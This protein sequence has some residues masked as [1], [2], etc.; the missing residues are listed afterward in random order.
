MRVS[1]GDAHDTEVEAAAASARTRRAAKA[2]GPKPGD[3]L[4]RFVILDVLGAGGMG[5]VYSAY[6]PQL[7]RR[8]AIKLLRVDADGKNAEMRLL[9][10]AQAMARIDHPNVIKVHDVGTQDGEV[11]LAME[12]SDAGTL[13]KWLAA[14]ARSIPEIV[15]AFVQAGRGL[16]AA[17]AAGLVHRDFKP[18][19]VLVATNGSVRVTDFGLVG[20]AGDPVAVPTAGSSGPLALDL[21]RTGAVLGTPSYM[22]PEQFAGETA[23]EASDQ[24]AFCV[25][26]YEACYGERPFRG[27]SHLD[28]ASRVQHGEIEPAPAGKRVPDWLRR[29]V[30][31]G[32]STDTARRY[33]SM[34]ALLDA[35]GGTSRRRR[36]RIAI[37]IGGAIA[38]CAAVAGTMVLL[39][40]DPVA[41]CAS[42]AGDEIAKVWSPA[43]RTD[44]ERAFA[45]SS[46][47]LA[48]M[49]IGRL[50]SIV[51]SWSD[52][53]QHAYGD[54]CRASRV[55]GTQSEHLFDLRMECLARRRDQAGASIALLAAG[56]DDAV[57]HALDVARGLPAVAPCADATALTAQVAPPENA[58]TASQVQ[59]I[60]LQIDHAHA[61]EKL[62][63]YKEARDVAAGALTAARAT[64]YRPIVA[65][66]LLEIGIA[67]A[68]LADRAALAS[69]RESMHVATEAGD[70]RA[71]VEATSSLTFVLA[72][73][74][75]KYDLAQELVEQA[76]ALAVATPPSPQIVIALATTHAFV[77]S[78]RGKP[79]D[80]QARLEKTLSYAER[81]LG[82]DDDATTATLDHLGTVLKDEGKFADARAALERVVATRERL[83][84]NDH[85]DV[86]GALS[87]LGNVYRREG[88]LD[89]AERVDDR[90]LAIR[91]AAL[92]PDHPEVAISYTNL[93]TLYDDKGDYARSRDYDDRAL[94]IAEKVFGPDSPDVAEALD[95]IGSLLID[96]GKHA[97][98][99]VP[100][101]R[102]EGILE[103]TKSPDDPKLAMVISNLALVDQNEGKLEAALA[104]FRRAAEIATKAYGPDHLD[105][106]DYLGNQAV[107][108][109]LQQKFDEAQA[110]DERVVAA[111]KA[112]YGPDH[113]R[114]AMAL[115][116]LG[117]VRGLRDDY[118]GQLDACREALAIF[119]AKLGKDHPYVSYA[120]LGIGQALR[121]LHRV[122]EA[123]PYAERALTIRKAAGMPPG[124]IAEATVEL[125]KAHALVSATHARGVAEI[126]AGIALWK[127]PGDK[128]TIAE[129]R[130]WLANHR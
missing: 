27:T 91:I 38:A 32:L 120:V 126:E 46:R 109:Q 116:N 102:A 90:A 51:D 21:T 95:N 89:D 44:V 88:K 124:Q 117:Y 29:V 96:Q 125:G 83:L 6:D 26:L 71:A 9:R 93:G 11:Y 58:A 128:A 78:A 54:A 23:S 19:N 112:I 30:V 7:D 100:L 55:Q 35:L 62:A 16:A 75:Q 15:D 28:L 84:G 82:P 70:L 42:G 40:Q 45:R 72:T 110:I 17:H 98:A 66:T 106:V 69:L 87:N 118:S 76:E 61:L 12:F 80:A 2:D 8:V 107:V 3:K 22:S 39:R 104:G 63:R 33:P 67:Q 122:A 65:A 31:R 77:D 119:E 130:A 97:E 53:W 113:V 25:A 36:G 20:T 108:F 47:P 4:G 56:G 92:G 64:G 24:F 111:D 41:A 129:A 85:P 52:G 114:V 79:A 74:F 13:R 1:E 86:A 121:E 94:A 73:A 34:T 101:E 37:A 10:E 50:T 103:A 5:V 68:K 115:N 60:R 105:V 43:T 59:A 14:E 18:D 57:D 123:V 127:E 48:K 49:T 81:T 99:R